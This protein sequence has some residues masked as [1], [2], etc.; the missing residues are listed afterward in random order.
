MDGTVDILSGLNEFTYSDGE[1]KSNRVNAWGLRGNVNTNAVNNYIGTADAN[2]FI[3]KRFNQEKLRFADAGLQVKDGNTLEFGAGVPGKQVD[4]GKIGYNAFGEG[5]TLSIVGGGNDPLGFDRRIKLW[6]DLGTDFTGGASFNK[7]VGI[8]NNVAGM[9]SLTNTNALAAGTTHSISFGGTNYTT[10]LLT[11]TG[12]S[13]STARMGF[14]TGYSFAGGPGNM[15][16]RLSI[17]NNGNV[18]VGQITPVAK[19]DVAGKIK[20]ADD[21]N[22]PAA[23]SI[24]YN[25]GNKDFEGFDGSSWISLTKN[26]QP[27]GWDV[28]ITNERQQLTTSDATPIGTVSIDDDYAFIGASA[29]NKVF[30]Y[31]RINNNWAQVLIIAPLGLAATDKFGWSVAVKDG[32]AVVGSPGYNNNGGKLYVYRLVSG[33][34]AYSHDYNNPVIGDQLGYKVYL[35][36]TS[37]Y[38]FQLWASRPFKTVGAN[39]NQGEIIRFWDDGPSN[40]FIPI[41][42]MTVPDGAANDRLGLYD[43]A[44]YENSIIIGLPFK[45][46]NGKVY[47][48]RYVGGGPGTAGNG[49]DLIYTISSATTNSKLG[50]S[51]SCGVNPVGIPTHVAIGAPVSLNPGIVYVYQILTNSLT[52]AQ[53]IN[54]SEFSFGSSVSMTNSYLLVGSN[55]GGAASNGLCKIYKQS[56]ANSWNFISDLVNADQSAISAGENF[57]ASLMLSNSGTALISGAGKVFFFTK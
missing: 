55:I 20:I 3:V 6:A 33:S 37:S 2:D 38:G 18:G 31:Q 29:V 24:R 12:T 57:G 34:W 52:L 25:N 39:A 42:Y 13:G 8:R 15:Q 36:N 30:V 48:V 9:L 50:F 54:S 4:N 14:S 17:A 35:T 27:K 19:L 40:T 5:N 22:T 32:V 44:C 49:W 41:A 23:G 1:W 21:V 53:T 47:Y 28:A 56:G 43:F 45:N 16:E 26:N 7:N 10:G 11:I 51:I 46:A